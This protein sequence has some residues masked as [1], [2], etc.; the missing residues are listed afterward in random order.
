MEPFDKASVFLQTAMEPFIWLEW[1]KV[2]GA[3]NYI[4]E[5]SDKEDFSHILLTKSQSGNRFLIKEKVPLG[6]L[7]WR[8][9]AES[10][11]SMAMSDWAATREFIIYHQKNETFVK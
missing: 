11:E 10:K 5:V 6:K 3:T 8:V 7:Y 4:V 9:R 1:K 2:E